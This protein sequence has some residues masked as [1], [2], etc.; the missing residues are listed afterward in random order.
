[1]DGDQRPIDESA[2]D[3]DLDPFASYFNSAFTS[4]PSVPP[5][6]LITTSAKSSKITYSFCDE[7]VNVIPG[8]EFIKRKKGKGYEMGNIASWAA[9]RGYINMLVVNEDRKTPSKY[10]V[11]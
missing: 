6:V 9:G 1:M 3:I 7:L 8:A 5:K 11:T 4:D 2:V 10:W